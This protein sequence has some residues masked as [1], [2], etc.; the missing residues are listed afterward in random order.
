M[1]LFP[2][3][4]LP[5]L[6][7]LITFPGCESGK[8]KIKDNIAYEYYE[9]GG[10]KTEA[11]VK[12]DTILHG[13]YKSYTPD[14]YLEKVFTYV[15][16]KR[17]GPAVTYY[18]N[19]QLRTKVNYHDNKMQGTASMYY[20]SGELY[21]VTNYESGKAE[22]I[23]TSYYKNGKIM[24]EIP[25]KND[26]PGLGIK[27][28]SMDGKPVRNLL[29]EIKIVPVN[30][31]ALEDTYILKISLSTKEHSTTFYIGDLEEGKY[32]H[33]G[34]WP[35]KPQNGE[36]DYRI[37]VHKGGFLMEPLTVSAMFMTAHKSWAVV[38]RT[39]NLAI[40]NK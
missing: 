19:G 1:R 23:R 15:D 8:P 26:Y 39:Y 14:G 30:R 22:G 40:D 24:S 21:R 16:G 6:I 5:A 17:E 29:P 32:I 4:F 28:Y 2:K 31:L 36:F 11:G 12:N 20:K 9:S 27:E 13:L 35:R 33:A 37:Q 7:F 10:I 38:S 34:L 18:N 3:I 25:Y